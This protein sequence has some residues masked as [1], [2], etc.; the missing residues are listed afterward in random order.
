MS[1]DPKIKKDMMD[2]LLDVEDDSGRKLSDE[3]I[4]DTLIMYLNAGH[5]SSGH[6]TMWTIAFLEQNPDV[7]AKAKVGIRLKAFWFS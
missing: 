4:I 7:F 6:V 1:D 5:E 2:A 3:Q